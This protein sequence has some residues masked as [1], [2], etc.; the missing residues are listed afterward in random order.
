M[1]VSPESA[2]EALFEEEDILKAFNNKMEIK[3]KIQN[4]KLR[5]K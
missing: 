5:R 4:R 1:E 3:L 2:P